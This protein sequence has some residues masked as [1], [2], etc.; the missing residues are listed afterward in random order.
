MQ[1]FAL[2]KHLKPSD[3]LD[4]NVP[5]FL[6]LDIGFSFLVV[7]NLLKHVSIVRVLH[8]K[9][10]RVSE[11]SYCYLPKGTARVIDEGLLVG[12]DVGM[13]NRC[14]NPHL[15]ERILFL[16]VGEVE[17]LDFLEGVDIVVLLTANLV[18]TAV[19]SITYKL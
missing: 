9:A 3:N 17:H 19:G 7:T 16:L 8:H 10:I 2:V 5:D 11:Q 13:R 18:D 15:V 1:N 4:E 12:N 6:F 14:Q